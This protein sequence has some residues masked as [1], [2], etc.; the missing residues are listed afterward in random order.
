MVLGMYL[1]C[2]ASVTALLMQAFHELSVYQN[3]NTVRSVW[4]NPMVWGASILSGLA[5][6]LIIPLVIGMFFLDRD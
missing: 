2:A 3:Y 5:W 4:K 1:F 6:P